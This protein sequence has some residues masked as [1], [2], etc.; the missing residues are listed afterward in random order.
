VDFLDGGEAAWRGAGR[1]RDIRRGDDDLGV[2][3]LLVELG[4]LTILVGGGH[5]GVALVFEPLADAELVLGCAW[6]SLVIVR[7]AAFDPS[8]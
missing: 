4:V 6:M 3:E 1:A 8:L 7:S 2:D 5:Q